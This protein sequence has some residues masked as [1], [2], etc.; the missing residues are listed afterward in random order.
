MFFALDSF[1]GK[2]FRLFANLLGIVFKHF[3]NLALQILGV[4]QTLVEGDRKEE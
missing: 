1:S 4:I 3:C 2:D